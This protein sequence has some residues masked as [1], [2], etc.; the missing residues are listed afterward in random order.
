LPLSNSA[1]G[2]WRNAFLQSSVEDNSGEQSRFPG[3]SKFTA[4]GFFRSA[5]NDA[6]S[7]LLVGPD[8]LVTPSS[9]PG[10]RKISDFC[11]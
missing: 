5:H 8:R 7:P 9:S 1:K 10:R 11:R 3:C 4:S 2:T 6:I